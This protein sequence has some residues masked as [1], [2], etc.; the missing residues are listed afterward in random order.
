[1]Y[2]Q[3]RSDSLADWN[4][5]NQYNSPE[6]Q[7]KRLKDA[8]LNPNLVYGNG[9]VGNASASITAPPNRDFKYIPQQ[10]DA[11]SVGD[12]VAA[13]NNV[14]QQQL[15]NDNLKAQNDLIRANKNLADA[16]AADTLLKNDSDYWSYLKGSLIARTSKDTW[17]AE[18]LGIKHDFIKDTYLTDIQIRK[19]ALMNTMSSIQ[20]KDAMTSYYKGEN[21]RRNALNPAVI[22]NMLTRSLLNEAQTVKT[23]YEQRQIESNITKIK[24]ESFL[25]F[26]EAQ[27]VMQTGSGYNAPLMNKILSFYQSLLNEQ[28][29]KKSKALDQF[30]EEYDKWLNK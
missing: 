10:V 7:M 3:Q 11:S 22:Q 28:P 21:Q 27:S 17:A 8:G 14:T 4:R 12:A 30:M 6:Q 29:G 9:S 13:Y 19:A 1:M 2:A 25:K 26:L 16:K 18:N 20:Q 5:I 24:S 15:Q 23:S